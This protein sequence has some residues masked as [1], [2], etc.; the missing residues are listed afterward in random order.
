[1]L[2]ANPEARRSAKQ[3]SAD[4]NRV[5]AVLRRAGLLVKNPTMLSLE[6]IQV[7]SEGDGESTIRLVDLYLSL[8]EKQRYHRDIAVALLAAGYVVRQGVVWSGLERGFCAYGHLMTYK[9]ED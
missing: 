6:N 2:T 4:T 5:K 9:L 3:N 7:R 1:M 8:E